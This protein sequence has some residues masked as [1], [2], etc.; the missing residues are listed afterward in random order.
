MA[1][2]GIKVTAASS[3]SSRAA[4]RVALC[5]GVSQY[6]SAPLQNTAHDASDVAALLRTVGFDA[7]LLLEPSVKQMLDALEA[8]V[9]SLRP[10]GTAVF[11]F[12]GAAQRA[13]ALPRY[14]SA[15]LTCGSPALHR[16]VTARRRRMAATI[17]S[18]WRRWRRT[19]TSSLAP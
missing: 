7:T 8:F 15:P 2:R 10:G 3:S 18:R 13:A 19:F 14:P 16:Q 17:S 5:I 12:A 11:F 6:A 4:E 1:A 9:A